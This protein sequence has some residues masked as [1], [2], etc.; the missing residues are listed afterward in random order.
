MNN[1]RYSCRFDQLKVGARFVCNG[2]M[3]IKK[4]SRTATITDYDRW[5]YYG[6]R[7]TCVITDLSGLTDDH[8]L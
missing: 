6:K 7:E 8:K 3:C 2:N 5:A 1:Q 4:S